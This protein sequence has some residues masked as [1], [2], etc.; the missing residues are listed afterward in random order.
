MDAVELTPALVGLLVDRLF[1]PENR[2]VVTALLHSY[3]SG[4]HEPEPVRV[5][6]AA[7]KLSGGD[8]GRLGEAVAQARKDYR[9][10]LAWAEYPTELGAP[11]WQLPAAEQARIRA[12]DR[13][14]YLAWLAAH[15]RDATS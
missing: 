10:V 7:F 1:P 2:A 13:G 3:G 14:E 4:P 9:D 6:V 11:M 8:A 5:R 12:A 15:T